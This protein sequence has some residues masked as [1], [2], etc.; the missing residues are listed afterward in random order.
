LF[1]RCVAICFWY[2]FGIGARV[3]YPKSKSEQ[4]RVARKKAKT[5]TTIPTAGLSYGK[6]LARETTPLTTIPVPPVTKI[7][8]APVTLD[9]RINTLT[10]IPEEAKVNDKDIVAKYVHRG[11]EGATLMYDWASHRL[12]LR[13]GYKTPILSETDDNLFAVFNTIVDHLCPEGDGVNKN[14]PETGKHI[15][16]KNEMHDVLHYD[17]GDT[18]KIA[19]SLRHDDLL[20]I[21]QTM[22]RRLISDFKEN[23]CGSQSGN[24]TSSVSALSF[25]SGRSNLLT[26]DKNT[27]KQLI[28]P[29]AQIE[30]KK[31]L[32]GVN[33]YFFKFQ[34][35]FI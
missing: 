1:L 32:V 5:T 4:E 29:V 11:L 15:F 28:L 9:V 7:V 14:Y 35:S 23:L 33:K 8:T 13:V 31:G 22:C 34:K 17:G 10:Q 2:F 3:H 24:S 25:S 21:P 6:G 19:P 30:N 18:V 26:A 16:F 27:I 12:T 20:F